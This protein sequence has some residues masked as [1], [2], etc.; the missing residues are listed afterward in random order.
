LRVP[1]GCSKNR[2]ETPNTVRNPTETSC[3]F[4]LVAIPKTNQH[5]KDKAAT[6]KAGEHKQ[7]SAN[8]SCHFN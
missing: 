6:R 3:D 1:S 4:L 8:R 2:L 5:K 7:D